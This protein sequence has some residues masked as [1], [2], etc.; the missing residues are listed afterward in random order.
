VLATLSLEENQG[1]DTSKKAIL[2]YNQLTPQTYLKTFHTLQREKG[3]N[4]RMF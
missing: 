2:D 4:F 3:E 1:C